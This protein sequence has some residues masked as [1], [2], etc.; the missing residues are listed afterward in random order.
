VRRQII[1]NTHV[2]DDLAAAGAIF[3]RE[4]DEVPDGAVTVLAAHG[5]SPTVRA[6]AG[7][8]DLRVIDATCP[9]VA[10]VHAEVR[11]RR[12]AGYSIVLIGHED[13]EE[14]AGT[15]GEAPDAIHVIATP[16]EVADLAVPDPDKVAYLTQTTLALDETAAV[17]ERLRERFPNVVGP[18]ANDICYATQNRQLAVRE[19]VGRVDLMLVVGSVNSSNSNRLVEVARRDGVAAHLVE[20]E[21][22]LD[23]SWLAGVRRIGVTA[24]ASAPE[25]LVQRVVERLASLGRVRVAEHA[26]VDEDVQFTLPVEVR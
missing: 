5:V 16:E 13:H 21:T 3:V 24:G 12:D 18:R 2:V 7:R 20:D 11:T 25:H 14:I 9:L 19:L 6:D 26:V 17:I 23:L 15:R 4:L 1:H 10:K 8:R 22:Q